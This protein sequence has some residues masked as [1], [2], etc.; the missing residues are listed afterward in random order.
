MTREIIAV[1]TDNIGAVKAM[2]PVDQA[3]KMYAGCTYIRGEYWDVTIYPDTARAAYCEGG[4]S[5]WGD[6]RHITIDGSKVVGGRIDFDEPG[7]QS[8][9]L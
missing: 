1:T 7:S 2:A 3:A 8:F 9:V 6:I 4:D 5:I